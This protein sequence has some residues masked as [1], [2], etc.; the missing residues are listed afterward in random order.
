MGTKLQGAVLHNTQVKTNTLPLK[1]QIHVL[2]GSPPLV[3]HCHATIVTSMSLTSPFVKILQACFLGAPMICSIPDFMCFVPVRG[4]E[5]NLPC[6]ASTQLA[7]SNISVTPTPS[8][9]IIDG[10]QGRSG[11]IFKN[12]AGFVWEEICSQWRAGGQ[13]E[14]QQSNMGDAIGEMFVI[15]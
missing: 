6:L 9:I 2:Q 12:L 5:S 14:T 8:Q 15:K 4:G 11:E 3:E 1:L 10:H 13:V 7:V